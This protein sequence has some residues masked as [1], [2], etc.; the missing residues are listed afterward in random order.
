MLHKSR[1]HIFSKLT[2]RALLIGGVFI[3]VFYAC[4][5]EKDNPVPDSSSNHEAG[6][7]MSKDG[8]IVLGKKLENPYSLENMEKAFAMLKE[9]GMI[10]FHGQSPVRH[11]HS[12]VRF[13]PKD[14]LELEKLYADTLLD[15]SD[16]PLDV[17]ILK[18][19]WKYHDPSIPENQPN[20]QYT[21]VGKD[22]PFSNG[23][24]HEILSELY[25]PELDD[26]ANLGDMD[27]DHRGRFVDMLVDQSLILTKNFS[28]TVKVATGSQQRQAWGPRGMVRVY[29]TRLGKY[30]P[31]EGV[32]MRARRWFIFRH[33]YT[34]KNGYYEMRPFRRR[35][36]YALFFDTPDFNVRQGTFGQA[37]INGPRQ[38]AP[39][40]V[41]IRDGALRFYA[42]VF[43]AGFR[44]HYGD[45]GGLRRPKLNI[46]LKI[47]AYDK[48][49]NVQGRN[50]GNWS[51]FG[52]NPNIFIYRFKSGGEEFDS[53][54]IFSSTIHEIAHSTHAQVMNA[55]LI[56]FAQVDRLIAESWAVGVE[57]FITQMEYRERG[58]PDH[59]SETYKVFASF[60]I[61]YGFQS[62][63]KD[64]HLI[65]NY[66]PLFIDLVDNFNQYQ[67]F[68]EGEGYAYVNDQVTGY[69][70]SFIESNFLHKV[71]GLASLREELK[72]HRPLGVSDQQ[73][74]LLIDS[75]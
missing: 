49:G 54:E 42:H 26:S 5:K 51:L 13:F 73:I 4:G 31:L 7:E 48:P 52:I 24:K 8:F 46:K 27:N 47:A 18:S 10:T 17:E 28:D 30:V 70:L 39:W 33:A 64:F 23:I 25:L 6:Y 9:K 60:P 14:S 12:Y 29:D 67:V 36:N 21:V 55:G 40:D 69:T 34:D 44:Y 3:T 71:Y 37:W 56:Q 11:T 57:W 53:D 58:I 74:D 22:Y 45:I 41:Y 35:A 38:A 63:N 66:T 61:H 72:K 43:R 20:C 15:L 16:I 65:P 1:F 50:I 19:G 59:S 32:R 68:F 2:L 62:W 75:F